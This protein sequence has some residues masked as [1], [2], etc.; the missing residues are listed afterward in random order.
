MSYVNVADQSLWRSRSD[1]TD[2]MR[3]TPP[4]MVVEV[5]SWS[6]DGGRIAFMARTREKPWRIFLVRQD[7]GNLAQVA[8]GDDNQG[9][10]S[11]SPDG[12]TIFYGSVLCQETQNCWIHRFNLVTKKD[13][14][15]PG[16]HGFRTARASHDGRFVAALW[17]ESHELK[18]FDLNSARW[19]TLAASV[20]GDNID[21]SHDSQYIFADS[22]QGE[23]PVIERFRVVDGQRTKVA[24]LKPLLRVSGDLSTWIGLSSDD[25]PILLHLFNSSE[26]YSLDW[27]LR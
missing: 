19:A 5:S 10:P 18:V 15:L 11:W 24:D 22:P 20:T 6:P 7:G 17:P 26:I 4:S 3:L 14:L 25:A 8:Q 16:S 9:G 23:R 1:G 27:R 21:W 2:V 13:E 12:S